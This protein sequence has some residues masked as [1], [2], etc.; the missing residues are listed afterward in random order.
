MWIC[1][2]G[3]LERKVTRSQFGFSRRTR[4]WS[5]TPG[6]TAEYV[7]N[8]PRARAEPNR[9]LPRIAGQLPPS[10]SPPAV[11]LCAAKRAANRPLTSVGSAPAIQRG[12]RG[13]PF[14]AAPPVV[15]AA[16]RPSMFLP[17]R[18]WPCLA[19]P[20]PQITQNRSDSREAL[21]IV[22]QPRRLRTCV[23]TFTNVR[24]VQCSNVRL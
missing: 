5:P 24:D 3:R 13:R 18:F 9:L 8:E 6:P 10:R 11:G 7:S 22:S 20:I 23:R 21:I 17:D 4:S 16:W 19:G 14:F 12:E 2:R 15:L 1:A